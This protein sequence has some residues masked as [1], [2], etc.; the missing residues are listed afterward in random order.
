MTEGANDLPKLHLNVKPNVSVPKPDNLIQNHNKTIPEPDNSVSRLGKI[1]NK[2]IDEGYEKSPTNDKYAVTKQKPRGKAQFP[3][4]LLLTY[5]KDKKYLDF[6]KSSLANSPDVGELVP[7][8]AITLNKSAM[9]M[10]YARANKQTFKML[11]FL[12]LDFKYYTAPGVSS[13]DLEFDEYIDVNEINKYILIKET[14][15]EK[16]YEEEEW[17]PDN[18]VDSSDLRKALL[19]MID[20]SDDTSHM[21]RVI[22]EI[23][24]AEESLKNQENMLNTIEKFSPS[25]TICDSKDVEKCESASPNV[26]SFPIVGN[27][28]DVEYNR[29]EYGVEGSIKHF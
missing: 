19:D 8:M 9:F 5:I 18:I 29:R 7:V 4:I 23:N 15:E 25:D 12:C 26:Q 1:F 20:S 27:G 16:F 13:D 6:V 17:K 11:K 10:C 24:Q 2:E 28:K 22:D 3:L 14:G 21:S